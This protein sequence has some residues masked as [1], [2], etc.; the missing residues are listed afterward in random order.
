MT[1]AHIISA[2]SGLLLTQKVLWR[3]YRRYSL[4]L[5]HL[6]PEEKLILCLAESRNLQR[7]LVLKAR[8]GSSSTAVSCS[9]G[10]QY[11]VLVGMFTE[12]VKNPGSDL[13]EYL[14]MQCKIIKLEEI[15]K[16]PEP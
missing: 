13:L 10:L 11:N 8:L 15:E 12:Q 7:G 6:Y 14:A 3:G 5:Y 2:K 4:K 16:T 9:F 1:Q